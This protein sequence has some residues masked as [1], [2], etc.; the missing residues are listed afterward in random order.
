[1]NALKLLA[2]A[3]FVLVPALAQAASP[4]GDS[5]LAKD[6]TP[7]VFCE[8]PYALCIKA[9]C[10]MLA[11]GQANFTFACSCDVLPGWSMGPAACS[12]RKP[13]VK[14][15]ITILMSTYSN[16]YNA[17]HRTM[18]C[19]NE[20]QKWAWCY[21]APCAVDP[22]DPTKAVCNCPIRKGK[23]Q[24]LGGTCGKTG[25]GCD[26]RWSAARPVNDKL[27]NDYFYAYMRKNH[28][29]Y[30]TNKPADLCEPVP[31]PTKQ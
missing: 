7:A 14:D 22:A 6:K 19:D 24:T 28:P 9:E 30:P 21:G 31:A 1:M 5:Y 12:A 10:L 11:D 25:G 16:A 2:L 18:S 3:A 20:D 26:G 8:G 4:Q 29:N 27:A 15:G 13:Y 23:M 17:K